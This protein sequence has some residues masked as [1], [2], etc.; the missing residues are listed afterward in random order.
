MRAASRWPRPHLTS[1]EATGRL[2]RDHGGRLGGAIA[3]VDDSERPCAAAPAWR[4]AQTG[5]RS[6]RRRKVAEVTLFGIADPQAQGGGSAVV[7]ARRGIGCARARSAPAW[8]R[9]RGGARRAGP[10]RRHRGASAAC[11][12]RPR[13]PAPR[14]LMPAAAIR[15]PSRRRTWHRHQRARR[16]EAAKASVV[17]VICVRK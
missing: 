10:P 5:S 2:L 14:P 16:V 17:R 12:S 7:A 1:R 8:I 15:G 6:A 11:G 13:H 4:G 3:L 9:R